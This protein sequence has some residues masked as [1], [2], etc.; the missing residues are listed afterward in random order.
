M[1][2]VRPSACDCL[3]IFAPTAKPCEPPAGIARLAGVVRGAGKQCI[4][5]DANIEGLSFILAGTHKP[6]DTW[7]RRAVKNITNNSRRLRS[8]EGYTV[9]PRY[10]RA[11]ADLGRVV[12][13]AGRQHGLDLQLA[14]YRDPDLSPLNSQDLLQ[15]A[16]S[17]AD[18][19]FFPYFSKRLQTLITQARPALIGFSLNFLSQALTTFAMIGFV[20]THF[21]E[22]QI[23]VGGGLMT[24]WLRNRLRHNP[25]AGL[26]DHLIAGPGEQPLLA[27]L[28]ISAPGPTP[29][30]DY[31]DLVDLPY[32]APGFILPYA[33]SSGCYWNRCSFCPEPAEVNPYTVLP[34]NRVIGDLTRLCR[35]T[36]PTLIHFLDNAVSPALMSALIKNPPGTPWYGFARADHQLANPKFCRRLRE[37]GCLMLKLGLES[38]DQGVL[39][40]MDKGIDL[41]LV[42][43]VLA[44]L[45]SAGIAAYVYLLFGTPAES[46][47]E[48]EKTMEFT[49]RHAREITFLNLAVFN[50]PTGSQETA[51]LVTRPFDNGDLGLYRDFVHPRGWDRK[52]IRLFLE[53]TFK[54]HPTINPIIQRDPPIFTSNHAPFFT[55]PD[56]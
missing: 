37:S 17:H 55:T 3:L 27:L 41:A 25:F 31:S 56:I 33:A 26:I 22:I 19:I 10:Q 20:K 23:V 24:S 44:A 12:A 49:I 14:N 7:S 35:A 5:L 15:A 47:V 4:L 21:P 42:D 36:K 11:V 53:R 54:K 30:P 51:Q 29:A 52:S 39:N 9:F 34:P 16:A 43:K 2:N 45:H 50:M 40:A 46:L 1:D 32:L 8:Q 18:N 6:E 28:G 38:G 13:L 48:A